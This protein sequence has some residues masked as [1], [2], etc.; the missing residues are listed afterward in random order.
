LIEDERFEDNRARL[1]HR[2]EL[3]TELEVELEAKT[4][5]EWFERMQAEGVPAA[6]VYDTFEVWDDP[7]VARRKVREAVTLGGGERFNLVSYPQLFDDERLPIREP[8]DAPGADTDRILS[9]LGYSRER[10]AELR[11]AGVV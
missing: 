11:E 6:P 9:S 7:H 8:V 1:E 5:V 3:E 4:A 2:A 10:I